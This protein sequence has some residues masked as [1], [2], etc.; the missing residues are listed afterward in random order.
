MALGNWRG[1]P[2]ISTGFHQ[3]IHYSRGTIAHL[4][5]RLEPLFDGQMYSRLEFDHSMHRQS[6]E[7]T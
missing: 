3:S 4:L 6:G 1:Q 7:V 2:A 5:R